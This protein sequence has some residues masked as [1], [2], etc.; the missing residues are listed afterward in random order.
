MKSRMK[1]VLFFLLL[2]AAGLTGCWRQRPWNRI[3]DFLGHLRCG[4]SQAE[5][6]EVAKSYKG[7]KLEATK[8]DNA[9]TKLIFWKDNTMIEAS[10]AADGL[11]DARVS[12]VDTIMHIK[13]LPTRDLCAQR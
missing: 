10:F 8:P 1:P 2:I 12:W 4:M 11:R 9:R 13:S 6:Q 3:D 5:A 7:L